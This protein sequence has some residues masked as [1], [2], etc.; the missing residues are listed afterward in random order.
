MSINV[1]R[2]VYTFDQTRESKKRIVK[3]R[4]IAKKAKLYEIPDNL[5]YN[6]SILVIIKLSGPV[7][8]ANKA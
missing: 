7:E 2:N 1:K 6:I 4:N 3:C 5:P 8:H